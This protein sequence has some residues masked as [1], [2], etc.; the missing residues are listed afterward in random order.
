MKILITGAGGFVGAAIA[1]RRA[2]THS[3]LAL[4]HHALDITNGAAV[5]HMVRSQRPDL[6]I[7]CAVL[8]VD[9][10]E[11]NPSLAQAVNV[12]GPQALAEASTEVGAEFLHFS[13]NY[14]FAGDRQ[15]DSPY[16]FQD[17]PRPVNV[18]GVTKLAGES[19]V[20]AA[21]ARNYIVRT[22]WVF[23]AGAKNFLSLAPQQLLARRPL[24]A[25]TDIRAS[26]TYLSDLLI[27]V[28]E[29]LT[30]Q[31]YGIYHLVN[32]G[33]CSHYEFALEAARGVGLTAIETE[34]LIEPVTEAAMKRVALRPRHTPLRCLLSEEI[35]LP[36]LRSWRAALRE[37][38][39]CA[40]GPRAG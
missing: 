10:C 27:R 8:G 4:N 11:S 26:A 18:Y 1:Q 16:T 20:L 12:D 19:A 7:N 9:V 6:I 5:R 15:E 13:T 33:V 35:G 21:A 28:D 31:R 25:V 38:I 14:V 2:A 39:N 32:E 29:I 17:I 24:R 30:R 36:A 3:I 40:S 34:G 22:S 37:H 23:G